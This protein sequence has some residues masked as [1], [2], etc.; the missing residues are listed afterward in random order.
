MALNLNDCAFDGNDV[1]VSV[2]AGTDVFADNTAFRDNGIGI[3]VRD[4]ASAIP[5]E[6]LREMLAAINGG[7]E[8]E[9]VRDRFG[10]KL[11][12]FGVDFDVWLAR[13][14]NIATIGQA[15][16]MALGTAGG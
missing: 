4:A 11:K 15:L 3:E 2:D 13:G 5:V 1:A 16:A 6:V 14:A 7:S 12:P 10:P 8:A 9:A